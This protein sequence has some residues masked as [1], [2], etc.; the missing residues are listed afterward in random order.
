MENTEPRSRPVSEEGPYLRCAREELANTLT[1][2]F[3]AILAIVGLVALVVVAS[4]R[5]AALQIVSYSIY[6]A[7]LV[8]LYTA[9]TCYHAAACDSLKRLF[10]RLD[11]VGISLLIAG[12][13]TPFMLL[14][15]RGA[16]GWTVLSLVWGLAALGIIIRLCARSR[17]TVL[18]TTIYLAMGWVV[19]IAAKPALDAIHPHGIAWLVAGGLAYTL[20]VIFFAL[21]RLPYNHTIWHLFVLG[22][23]LCHF[24]AVLFYAMPPG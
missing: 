4:G 16:W 11:H 3:G 23:S 7:S 21:E 2:G 8:F 18:T 20:G 6:G 10:W 19:V 17:M 24:L 13:Y 1:H 15:V 14:N 12:T 5:G 9:S 22:G